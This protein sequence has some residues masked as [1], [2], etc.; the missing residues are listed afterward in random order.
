MFELYVDAPF[1]SM[2]ESYD[3]ANHVLQTLL[4]RYS[5]RVFG[6]S[7]FTL[8]L[9]SVV[10]CGA[11]AWAALLLS[12][13]FFGA[14]WMLPVAVAALTLNPFLLDFFVVAR[15]YGLAL[16]LFAWGL[17]LLIRSSGGDPQERSLP[18]AGLLFGLSIAANLTFLFAVAGVAVAHAAATRRLEI[19]RLWGPGIVP[20][21]ALMILP[22][23]KAQ[24]D[25]FY[26]GAKSL[27][28]TAES[29]LSP[30]L[31]RLA[32]AGS[33]I[34]ARDWTIR[35]YGAIYVVPALVALMVLVAVWSA[36]RRKELDLALTGGALAATVVL[37]IAAHRL[38]GVLYPLDRTGI[39]LAFLFTLGLLLLIREGRSRAG[40]PIA[41]PAALLLCFMLWRFIALYDTRSVDQ[42]RYDAST[43]Q[44]MRVLRID[45]GDRQVRVAAT[46]TLKPSFKFYRR[47]WRLESLPTEAGNPTE[48]EYDYY[49]LD[50]MDR[51]LVKERSLEPLFESS[52]SGAILARPC[53]R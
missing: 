33:T 49:L 35:N 40:L 43:K 24:P 6:L 31:F 20:A 51:A 29:L 44:M 25:N 18:L 23:A 45:A 34:S 32:E 17:Y 46:W 5:V 48:G 28:E 7:E 2:L 53:P 22:L 39:A 52:I 47:M 4:A 50:P 38:A 26:Y 13:R 42:W 19:D 27:G 37:L 3:A 21:F 30:A 14:R 41:V 9:P 8:R 16:A 10:S 12:L 1:R 15:G 11:Y 36:L